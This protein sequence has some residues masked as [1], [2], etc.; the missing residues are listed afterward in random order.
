MLLFKL[1]SQNARKRRG[2]CPHQK[3]GRCISVHLPHEPVWRSR[4][5][6]EVTG[7]LPFSSVKVFFHFSSLPQSF[8]QA[9]SIQD[10]S[11][12]YFLDLWHFLSPVT[13][14]SSICANFFFYIL[15]AENPFPYSRRD[16][17]MILDDS[18]PARGKG[19]ASLEVS[20]QASRKLGR[21]QWSWSW[22]YHS[23]KKQQEESTGIQIQVF[24]KAAG[25]WDIQNIQFPFA[26]E[27]K[28]IIL[29]S[30]NEH[31]MRSRD[32]N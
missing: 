5:F 14:F 17:L 24:R 31:G 2:Y 7:I 6:L 1:K 3:R 26:S 23:H 28:G 32:S 29:I 27:A 9:I 16:G 25:N 8:Q 12:N 11:P 15:T 22:E 20:A 21:N 30:M 10:I 18:R 19:G 4:R 13:T